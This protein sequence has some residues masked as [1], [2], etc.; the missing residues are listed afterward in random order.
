[1]YILESGKGEI[2]NTSPLFEILGNIT[3]LILGFDLRSDDHV[4]AFLL[5]LM[6]S[7]Q[8]SS[9]ACRANTSPCWIAH[10]FGA[11]KKSIK[12]HHGVSIIIFS[13][14]SLISAG[15]PSLRAGVYLAV[16]YSTTIAADQSP[17][18]GT[19]NIVGA[20]GA[21]ITGS[22]EL[23]VDLTSCVVHQL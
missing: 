16:I 13:I 9:F 20:G 5:A 21:A 2:V 4:Q 11:G 3:C 8:R 12:Q 14:Q 15:L 18:D 7:F 23:D 19:E 10:T 1:M 6:F 22:D 17:E